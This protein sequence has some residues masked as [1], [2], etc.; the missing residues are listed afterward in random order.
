M[1]ISIRGIP[2]KIDLAQIRSAAKWYAAYLM[3]TKMSKEVSLLISFKQDLKREQS[4][5]AECER[6]DRAEY[7]RKFTITLDAHCGMRSTMLAL[8]HEMVHVKQYA[9]GELHWPENPNLP[10]RWKGKIVR[11]DVIYWEHPWEVEA[12]G[13]EYGLYVMWRDSIRLLLK[14]GKKV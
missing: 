7:P 5:W 2:D 12:Y 6:R 1:R 4:I 3:G 8:A 13:R 10:I 14:A 11:D 9:I